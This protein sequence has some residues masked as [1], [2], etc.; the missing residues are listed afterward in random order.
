MANTLVRIRFDCPDIMVISTRRKLRAE[1]SVVGVGNAPSKLVE[2]QSR[3]HSVRS[4]RE[5]LEFE[6]GPKR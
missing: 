2:N 3:R 1:S 4:S 5:E 6:A